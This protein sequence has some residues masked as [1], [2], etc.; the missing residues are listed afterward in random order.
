MSGHLTKTNTPNLET[1][2]VKRKH[3]SLSHGQ[4]LEG[5]QTTGSAVAELENNNKERREKHRQTSLHKKGHMRLVH[6]GVQ[7]IWGGERGFEPLVPRLRLSR[8][9]ENKCTVFKHRGGTDFREESPQSAGKR[10]LPPSQK[11]DLGENGGIL[12]DESR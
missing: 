9:G 11:T 4:M 1:K 5:S 6:Q 8:G 7:L 12:G 10:R 3:L 2:E